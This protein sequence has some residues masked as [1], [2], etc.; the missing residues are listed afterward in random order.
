MLSAALAGAVLGLIPGTGIPGT[1]APHAEPAGTPLAARPLSRADLP[2]WAKRDAEKRAEIAGRPI[3]MVWLGDSITQNFE[4][5]SGDPAT[6]YAA[7]WQRYYGDRDALN[8]GFTGDATAHVLWRVLNGELAGIDPKLVVLLVGANNL[9]KLRWPAADTLKGV[10]AIISALHQK[11]PRATVLLIATL[12][13]Q[14]DSWV[15]TNQ[16]AIVQGLTERY[17]HAP[18]V[19]FYD[20]S[21]LFEQNGVIRTDAYA[22]PFKT[23]PSPALHPNA[24]AMARLAAAIEPMVAHVLGDR[25]HGGD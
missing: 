21:A 11:L 6:D 12:P 20:P 9:G 18:G 17:A 1:G 4:K 14:G 5:H 25:V 3:R 16:R 2:W 23:P 13:R 19:I 10:D 15:T 24:P 22:D 8:L 7:V